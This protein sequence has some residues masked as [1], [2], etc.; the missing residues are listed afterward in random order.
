V[1]AT[2]YDLA[3]AARSTVDRRAAEAREAHWRDVPA[4]SVR[5]DAARARLDAIG[6]VIAA[7]KASP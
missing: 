6:R 1:S 5:L 2:L 7:R 4:A 3:T